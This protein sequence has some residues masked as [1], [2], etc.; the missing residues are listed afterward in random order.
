MNEL[1][2]L[3]MEELIELKKERYE[4]WVQYKCP[5]FREDAIALGNEISRREMETAKAETIINV[6]FEEGYRWAVDVDGGES[7]ETGLSKVEAM[8]L[9]R[10]LKKKLKK[11]T[12]NEQKLSKLERKSNMSYLHEQTYIFNSHMA[13]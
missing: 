11:A 2:Q 6:T 10:E 4:L 5:D 12:I 13:R 9:A 7:I 1:A 8:S 3:S